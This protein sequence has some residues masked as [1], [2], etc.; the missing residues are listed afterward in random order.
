VLLPTLEYN[1]DGF[2]PKK[3]I[4]NNYFA[5]KFSTGRKILLSD[6]GTIQMELTVK[7]KSLFKK[8]GHSR[9]VFKGIVFK[10]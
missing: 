9:K 6:S 1:P 8:A 3:I 2:I 10:K 7:I 5:W 4:L